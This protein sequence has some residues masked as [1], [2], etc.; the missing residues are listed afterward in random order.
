MDGSNAEEF[1]FSNE[2][3]VYDLLAELQN[4]GNNSE[5]ERSDEN[6]DKNNI[7]DEIFENLN[8]EDINI[9]KD[10]SEDDEKSI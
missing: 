1:K 10:D 6:D 3:E 8:E 4:N 9:D 5:E 2:L 7:E